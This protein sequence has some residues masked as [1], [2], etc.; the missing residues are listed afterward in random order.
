MK[1]FRTFNEEA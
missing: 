1:S